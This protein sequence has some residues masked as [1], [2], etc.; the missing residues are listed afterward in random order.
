[1]I[2]EDLGGR[3][4][5]FI[6]KKIFPKDIKSPQNFITRIFFPSKSTKTSKND[7]W[8]IWEEY[9]RLDIL[10]KPIGQHYLTTIVTRLKFELNTCCACMLFLFIALA[11]WLFYEATVYITPMIVALIISIYLW[12][13]TQASQRLLH[14]IR[15]NILK[16]PSETKSKKKYTS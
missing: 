6:E 15:K 9:L 11:N 16:G 4:E 13:E 1:M 14:K 2:I 7:M 12:Y 10:S 8:K 5:A 3:M